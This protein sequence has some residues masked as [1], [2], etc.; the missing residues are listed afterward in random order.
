MEAIYKKDDKV[1]DIRFGWGVIVCIENK[2]SYPVRVSFQG[3]LE[4]Y[5]FDGRHNGNDLIP[6]LSFTT[7]E[8]KGF[9]QER[10]QSL[11]EVGE[12]IMV[13]NDSKEWKLWE[14]VGERYKGEEKLIYCKRPDAN[15]HDYFTYFKRLKQD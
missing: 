8:L 14:F 11:P 4:R 13:T 3:I 15:F 5:N 7:Y 2:Q 1:Y 12:L 6:M 10:P 9:S